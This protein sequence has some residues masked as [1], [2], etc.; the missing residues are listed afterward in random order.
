MAGPSR[1]IKYAPLGGPGEQYGFTVARILAGV[2][3][4]LRD[5]Y[6]IP[7]PTPREVASWIR[8]LDPKSG[9]DGQ[10]YRYAGGGVAE[11]HV[12]F[13]GLA[14]TV[15]RDLFLVQN[16]PDLE[17]VLVEAWRTHCPPSGKL[18]PEEQ[19]L[20]AQLRKELDRQLKASG[21][22]E[23]A[24]L[25]RKVK[26]ALAKVEKLRRESP[27]VAP[28][29]RDGSMRDVVY[30][31]RLADRLETKEAK[32][33]FVAAIERKSQVDRAERAAQVAFSAAKR[34]ND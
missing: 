25:G 7:A 32:L 9:R 1:A 8:L 26:L 6:N 31:A 27:R 11:P 2:F 24:A 30:H 4:G 18:T 13:R 28:P 15:G 3:R 34:G 14:Q 29:P 20:S 12:A 33:A 19:R 21:I 16:W 5:D 23:D 17:H 22:A 10:P